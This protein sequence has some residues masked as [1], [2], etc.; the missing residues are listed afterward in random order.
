M[1]GEHGVLTCQCRTF[2]GNWHGQQQGVEELS[3]TSLPFFGFSFAAR[4]GGV[5]GGGAVGD[6]FEQIKKRKPTDNFF[7][8]TTVNRGPN[9]R[10]L[11]ITLGGT[12]LHERSVQ[13][14]ELY[15]TTHNTR[16]KTDIH[17]L[18]E[19]EPAVPES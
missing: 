16:K 18:S 2:C 17:S 1:G 15:L 4:A 7:Y 12:P 6:K 13:R 5:G 11:T 14:R 3:Q 19:F 10:S 8:G 9:Y